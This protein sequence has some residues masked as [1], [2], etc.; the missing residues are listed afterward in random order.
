MDVEIERTRRWLAGSG[1]PRV[2]GGQGVRAPAAGGMGV[3]CAWFPFR[4]T[5]IQSGPGNAWNTDDAQVALNLKESVGG[6]VNQGSD[7][8]DGLGT[9]SAA[10][11][12]DVRRENGGVGNVKEC[13]SQ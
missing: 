5:I 4:A 12:H 1:W 6:A 7:V 9:Q 11:S 13:P 10:V 3:E 8:C 2:R